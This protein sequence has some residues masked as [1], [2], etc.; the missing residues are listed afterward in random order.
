MSINEVSAFSGSISIPGT[1]TLGPGTSDIGTVSVA[2]TIPVS[3]SFTLT[4]SGT[5]NVAGTV[6]LGAGT[7][8]IGHAIIDSGTLVASAGTVTL[9]GTSAISGAVTVTSGSIAISNTPT[10]VAG[11]GTIALLQAG[12]IV[13]NGGSVAVSSV[14]GTVTVAGTVSTGAASAVS[15]VAGT[16]LEAT[17]VL[18]ASAG[19]C[20]YVDVT[21]GGTV[22]G[23][24]TV[25]NVTSAPGT[26][27]ITPLLFAPL[28]PNGRA[29]IGPLNPGA[30]FSTGITVVLTAAASPYT[31]TA[32]ITGAITGLVV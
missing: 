19:T 23:F 29:V 22:A 31:Y 8:V 16:A 1:I 4:P 6:E 7:A 14:A 28:A 18:K 24:A 3:G 11:G 5:Q 21:N 9:S 15:P 12:T 27:S 2:G 26:G 25:N 13:N 17:Q 10:V 20:Y 30:S 32:G